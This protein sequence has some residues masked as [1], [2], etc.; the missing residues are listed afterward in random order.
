MATGKAPGS[1]E[2]RGAESQAGCL[3]RWC[4]PA[5]TPLAY[6]QAVQARYP[7]FPRSLACH[8]R[9]DPSLQHS[10]SYDCYCKPKKTI[11]ESCGIKDL[12]GHPDSLA[13]HPM[14]IAGSQA[15]LQ[16]P[17]GSILTLPMLAHL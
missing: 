8:R 17:E 1:V 6:L 16:L 7:C 10:G 3:S 5:P 4:Q 13:T 11:E 12:Q 2:D 14:V 9:V 15:T